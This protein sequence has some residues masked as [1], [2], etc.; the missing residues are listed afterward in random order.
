MSMHLASHNT[1][2]TFNNYEKL[3]EETRAVI[4]YDLIPLPALNRHLKKKNLSSK[5]IILQ[6]GGVTMQ[7]CNLQK[8]NIRSM[9][10]K[11]FDTI[12]ANL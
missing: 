10:V 9:Y 6:P 8:F 4:E 11:C 3:P 5:G 7:N 1:I 12:K 2:K